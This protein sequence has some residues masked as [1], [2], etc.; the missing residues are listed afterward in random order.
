MTDKMFEIN[1]KIDYLFTNRS[2][3][4]RKLVILQILNYDYLF[5]CTSIC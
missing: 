2:V 5:I 1:I 3:S 4:E